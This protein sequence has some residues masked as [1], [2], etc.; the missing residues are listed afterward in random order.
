MLPVAVFLAAFFVFPIIRAL[1][2]STQDWTATSFVTGQADVV[3]LGNYVSILSDSLFGSIAWQTV[4]FV[5]VSLIGQFTI[6]LALAVFFTKRFPLSVTFRSLILLPW[7]LP[8]VVSATTW[9]WMFDQRFG[10][11]NAV[12]G[13][14]IGWLSDPRYSL[15]AVI[16][17]NIWLGIPF[18][19]V[20]LHGGLQAIPETLYEAAALDGAGPWRSFWSISWP[21]LRPVASVTLLLGLIYTIKVFDVIWVMTRG[22]PANSSHTLATWSYQLSFVD[23]KF[24]LGA[25]A[26]QIT[27]LVALVFGLVYVRAQRREALS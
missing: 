14:Q 9:R 5:V 25:A 2:L 7:L 1:V 13:H 27:V 12:L 24:G 8:L 4:Q 21:L 20:L 16:I 15:W 22:G 17:T 23:L 19:M 3:G 6:G 18:N 11:V 10:I 26:S